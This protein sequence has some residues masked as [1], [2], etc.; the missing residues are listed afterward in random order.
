MTKRWQDKIKIW[1]MP[2]GWRPSDVA[3]QFPI[4]V[5]PDVK[6]QIKYNKN[7]APTYRGWIWLQLVLSLC[8]LFH[9]FTQIENYNYEQL[10]IYGI[11]IMFN[12]FSY[13]ALMDGQKVTYFGEVGKCILVGYIGYLTGSWFGIP[14]WTMILFSAA[15]LLMAW[16]TLKAEL[17]FSL[18]D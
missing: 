8:M 6:Q 2:T 18:T 13:G 7:N 15:S 17:S 12:I 5:L 14:L 3:I 10:V 9:F 1:F 16:L 11:Y 4:A